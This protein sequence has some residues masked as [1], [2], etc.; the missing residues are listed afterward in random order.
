M[1]HSVSVGRLVDL[2]ATLFL[3][4][5]FASVVARQMAGCIYAYATQSMF[6]AAVALTIAVATGAPHLFILAGVVLGVKVLFIP[7]LLKRSIHDSIL[8]KRE[9]S[10]YFGVPASLVIS[11]VLVVVSDG[12]AARLP[13]IAVSPAAPALSAGVA[14]ILIGFWIMISRRE[15]VPQVVG[16]LTAENGLM[17]VALATVSCLPLITDMGILLDLVAGVLIMGILVRHMVVV[18]RT[19]DTARLQRLKG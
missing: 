12:F 19:T 9:L 7:W 2:L 11:G 13:G 16:L 4:S 14:T 5:T 15:A 3:I 17:L 10:F 8:E 18:G 1:P 6:L